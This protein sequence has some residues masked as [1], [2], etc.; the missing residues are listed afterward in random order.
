MK[1]NLLSPENEV[2]AA[3]KVSTERKFI[4]LAKLSL[5]HV[6][7]LFVCFFLR[8]YLLSEQ[9]ETVLF[10]GHDIIHRVGF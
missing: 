8:A 1:Q 5:V 9:M 6:G 7:F 10:Q 3:E 2:L 4:L